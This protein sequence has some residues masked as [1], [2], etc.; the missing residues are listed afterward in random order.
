MIQ[1]YMVYFKKQVF[2]YTNL[3]VY[4]FVVGGIFLRSYLMSWPAIKPLDISQTS[5]QPI[6]FEESL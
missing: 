1:L 2:L 5:I 6:V 3:F 4:F